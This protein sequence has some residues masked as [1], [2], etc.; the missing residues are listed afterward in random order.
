M[1]D[2]HHVALALIVMPDLDQR[3]HANTLIASQRQKPRQKH[4]VY[5]PTPQQTEP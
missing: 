3:T 2:R 1:T 5:R 4:A